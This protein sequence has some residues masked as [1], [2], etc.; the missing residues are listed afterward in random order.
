MEIDRGFDHRYYQTPLWPLDYM[1]SSVLDAELGIKFIPNPAIGYWIQNYEELYHFS[2][3]LRD[4]YHIT[5]SLVRAIP[6]IKRD[7][8]IHH[9]LFL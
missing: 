9:P 4:Y 1:V 6:Y 8:N 2:V 3:Q 5:F 7:R